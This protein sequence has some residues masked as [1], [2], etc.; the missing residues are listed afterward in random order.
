MG[1][2]LRVIVVKNMKEKE[3]YRQQPSFPHLYITC[4]LFFPS[5]DDENADK[6]VTTLQLRQKNIDRVH[7]QHHHRITNRKLYD[8]F[9][10]L[11]ILPALRN[12]FLA[13]HGVSLKSVW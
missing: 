4:E 13:K 2:K 10:I 5:L 3:P 7:V 8:C 1:L 9:G 11:A 6:S 12:A